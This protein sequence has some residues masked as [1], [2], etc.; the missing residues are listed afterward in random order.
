M[1]QVAK[2]KDATLYYMPSLLMNTFK[3]SLPIDKTRACIA[4]AMIQ[5]ISSETNIQP[6]LLARMLPKDTYSRGYTFAELFE[7][8]QKKPVNISGVEYHLKLSLHEYKMNEVVPALKRGTPILFIV[9]S[10]SNLITAMADHNG[11]LEDFEKESKP[12][13]RTNH[14]MIMFAYDNAEK[15]IVVRDYDKSIGKNGFYKVHESKLS[16]YYKYF[17]IGVD[18]VKK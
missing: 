1:A 16:R 10:D 2:N 11:I 6:Q 4:I 17:S 13:Y 9:D 8:F 12:A 5:A 14:A 7:A 18:K 3:L 15:H